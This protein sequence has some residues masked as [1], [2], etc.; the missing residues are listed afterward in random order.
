MDYI[1]VVAMALVK[2]KL[3]LN[4]AALDTCGA[5]TAG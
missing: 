2:V 5:G 1:R 3:G 4:A